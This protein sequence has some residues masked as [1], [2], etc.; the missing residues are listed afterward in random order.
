MERRM[1][2]WVAVL[3]TTLLAAACGSTTGDDTDADADA[4]AEGLGDEFDVPTDG[5]GDGPD[6]VC[7]CTSDEECR[8]ESYCNGEEQCVAC[9]CRPGIPQT[10]GTPCDDGE[11]CTEGESCLAGVCTG[12][13]SV[14]LC[15]DDDDCLPHDDGNRCNGRLLCVGHECRFAPET[16]ITCDRT[17]DTDC[18]I[19]LCVPA[20][21]DCEM[22]PVG[23]GMSCDDGNGCTTGDACAAG[24]C[25]GGPPTCEC[26]ATA[27]CA[28]HEDGNRCNG[29]LVCDPGTHTCVIDP[30]TVVTCD[31]SG[32]TACRANR[33]NPATG[34]CAMQPRGDGTSCDDGNACTVGDACA[35]GACTGAP[36]S[37]DDGN[38]CTDDGCD[39]GS[40]CTHAHNTADCD[41]G[42]ACTVDD[43]CAA[44][45]C[46][47]SARNCDDDNVCTD[48]G[49]DPGSGC[50]YAHN[51]ADC[52][53]GNACTVD[54]VCAA[55]RCGGAPRDCDDGNVCTD[56]GCDPATGC[57]RTHNTAPCDDGNPCTS[58]DA[59][60]GGRC[61]GTETGLTLCPDGGC[62]DLRT[63]RNHCGDCAV[64]CRF[65]ENC[66][67]GRC[68]V[69][70]WDPV[71]P[72]PVNPA[73]P[74]LAHALGTDGTTPYVAWVADEA[75]DNAYV[76]RLGA[77]AWTPLGGTLNGGAEAQAVVDIQ[78]D[79]TTPYVFYIDRSLLMTPPDHVKRFDG[80]G[81]G[82]V[83]VG[84]PGYR[85]A[86]MM[87]FNAALALDGARPHFSFVGS[88]GC[89]IGVGYARW[90]GTAWWDTPN[91][92]S[93]MGT[94]L[95][96]MN[97][98]G[99]SDVV[100]DG[101]RALVALID[102]GWRYVRR[103]EVPVDPGS[104]VNV[105]P[106]FNQNPPAAGTA[107]ANHLWMALDATG[108]IWVA[109]AEQDG[110]VQ[111]VFVKRYE[112]LADTW[113]LIGGEPVSDP[114]R[115]SDYPSLAFVDRTPHVAW[116]EGVTF[117]GGP[118]AASGTI[119]VARWS[120][121][122]WERV[123]APLNND[124]TTGA[125]LPY[126]VGIGTV[127]Y[128]AFREPAAAP[129]RIY[130]KRFP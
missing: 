36:R 69:R 6:G 76:H 17:G 91:P 94:G 118:G 71:G 73:L 31:P 106:S 99:S 3:A 110:G 75:T 127:P 68:V 23:D 4:P 108:R 113:T 15:D 43:V 93:P 82:W 52:D 107:A 28:R 83:E 74:A 30:G 8:D 14:C 21:G 59:C 46:G 50:T 100:Y 10:D 114:T 95:L 1:A 34:I 125:V 58:P 2:T 26:E 62:Y 121:L 92:P 77:A 7:R 65:D 39:P 54:D 55:G 12:G 126:L 124:A 60:S 37:C 102:N 84:A 122:A 40:G 45:R 72:G 20:T 51:T 22:T 119:K 78:F 38:V 89:G 87:H 117:S 103:W 130:V 111:K 112:P 97:G 13:A 67:D 128:V 27:D 25:V 70:A 104:W 98:G 56:D 9:E 49:C 42:N 86:C 53:D 32:D 47:G 101:S 129:Q 11:S 85:P 61:V 79:R 19:N 120:G 115:N 24:T 44:G 57:T 29:T 41:D 90:T 88:G 16:I 18:L 96:T 105:G 35:A 33:C 81:P 80:A 64:A 48:D 66:A 116:V 63:D 123:G 5:D 109:F